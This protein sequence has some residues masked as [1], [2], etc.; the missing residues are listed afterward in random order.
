[1]YYMVIHKCTL[2]RKKRIFFYGFSFMF[3]A[4]ILLTSTHID[5]YVLHDSDIYTKQ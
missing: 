3:Y 1:M 5:L 2:K 4:S